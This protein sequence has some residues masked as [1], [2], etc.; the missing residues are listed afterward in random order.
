VYLANA[1][2]CQREFL[3]SEARSLVWYDMDR[4]VL[5]HIFT[6]LCATRSILFFSRWVWFLSV[7]LTRMMIAFFFALKGLICCEAWLDTNCYLRGG[8]YI[9]PSFYLCA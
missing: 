3:E 4:L 1:I 8:K 6:R 5:I 9:S 7:P 2:F